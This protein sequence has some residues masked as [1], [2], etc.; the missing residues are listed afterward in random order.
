MT[1]TTFEEDL[2]HHLGC[3]SKIH[4]ISTI[5]VPNGTIVI[6]DRVYRGLNDS[7]QEETRV[8]FFTLDGKLS[9]SSIT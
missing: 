6:F 8:A 9:W 2:V 3:D 1:I 5:M 4:I 7:R